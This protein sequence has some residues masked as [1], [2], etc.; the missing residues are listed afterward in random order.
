MSHAI[1]WPT[2]ALVLLS[3]GIWVKARVEGA[4]HLY[5]SQVNPESIAE[6]DSPLRFSPQPLANL[7]TMFEMP[8][9]YFGLV[10]LLL[11]TSRVTMAQVV[12]AWLFVA[13]HVLNSIF[14]NS[15]SKKHL[16]SGVAVLASN[17][18]LAAMWVTFVVAIAVGSVSP[19]R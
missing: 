8:V 5:R 7:R 12:L 17:I 6:D 18:A 16:E 4:M 15:H 11:V 10:P 13:T 9:L 3:F 19:V 14:A 1:L 2:F